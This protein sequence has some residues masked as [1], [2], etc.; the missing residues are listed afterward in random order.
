MQQLQHYCY[1]EGLKVK[2][3]WREGTL[4]LGHKWITRILM[5]E[6]VVTRYPYNVP[7]L[8][9]QIGPEHKTLQR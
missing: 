8:L 1:G 9:I 4:L 7:H 6:F 3:N 2:K 5:I